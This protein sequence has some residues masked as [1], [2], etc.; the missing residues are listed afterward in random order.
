[1]MPDNKKLLLGKGDT[2][3]STADPEVCPSCNKIGTHRLQCP[4]DKPSQPWGSWKNPTTQK[5]S[6]DHMSD[7]GKRF[8]IFREELG[9]Y[10]PAAKKEA[11][12]AKI[13]SVANSNRLNQKE[14]TDK[15]VH[16]EPKSGRSGEHTVLKQGTSNLPDKSGF[17]GAQTPLTFA[18]KRGGELKPLQLSPSAVKHRGE[19]RDK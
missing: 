14:F 6:E 4:N 15:I 8:K 3:A 5:E 19:T 13:H 10:T 7:A 1:M 2:W 18:F 11:T 17:K 12:W 9:A 16:T